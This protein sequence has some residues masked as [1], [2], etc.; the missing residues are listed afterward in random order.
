MCLVL[1]SAHD[2]KETEAANLERV[3]P[4]CLQS[5]IDITEH[6]TIGDVTGLHRQLSKE[7]KKKKKNR[8]S[9]K[10]HNIL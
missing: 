7:K 3:R 5:Y 4:F 2:H 8:Q 6:P 9:A 10:N 1:K